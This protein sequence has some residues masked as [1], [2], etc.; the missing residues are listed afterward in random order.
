M[1]LVEIN[2]VVNDDTAAGFASVLA[3]ANALKAAMPDLRIGLD[4]QDTA[5]PALTAALA[6]AG[7]AAA[8]TGTKMND[9]GAAAGFFGA[10]A[11]RAAGW[12]GG[13]AQKVDLFGGVLNGILPSWLAGASYLH[14]LADGILEVVAVLAPAILGMIAFGAA[15]VPTIEAIKTQMS[16]LSTV[17]SATGRS[18]YPL[19]GA[20]TKAADAAKPYVYQLFGDALV[21][22]GN[23]SGVFTAIVGAVGNSLA[24]LGGRFQMAID[25]S[26]GFGGIMANA[27]HDVYML[28]TI[29]GNLGGILGAVFRAV[30]GYAQVFLNLANV[31]TAT[32]EHIAIAG[33]PLL[34]FGLLAHGAFLY[35][36]LGATALA[37]IIP[38]A[39]TALAGWGEKAAY[40]ADKSTILGGALSK[41]APS[42]LGFATGAETAAALPWGWI[43]LAAAGMAALVYWMVSAKDATQQWLSNMQSALQTA[44][45]V[46]GLTMLMAD[47]ASVASQLAQAHVQLAGDMQHVQVTSA[48]VGKGFGII[49]TNVSDTKQ[50]ISE[51]GAGYAQLQSQEA[52]YQTH[53]RALSSQYGGLNIAQGLVAASGISMSL[54]MQKGAGA[55][56]MI[57]AQIL[58]TAKAY[59]AMGQTGGILGA[60]MA[61][62][63]RLTSDQYAAMQKL[64]QAWATFIGR[65]A[66]VETA[67]TGVIAQMRTVDGEARKAR[68]SFTGVN[69]ASLTLRG[70]MAGLVTQTQTMVQ[71]MKDAHAPASALAAE[72]GTV[73]KQAVDAGA[74]TNQVFYSTISAMARQAGYTG[75]SIA[76]LK[77]WIDQN[78]TST[79]KLST[80]TDQYGQ[81]LTKLP[82]SKHTTVTNTAN[83]AN[84]QAQNYI[85][86][87]NNI[88]RNIFTQ[89][90]VNTVH[91]GHA[92]G[93]ITGAAS[94]GARGGMTLVGERGPELVRL[95][96]G[97]SVYSAGDTQSMMMRGGVGGG[98]GGG[99]MALSWEGGN[100]DLWDFLRRGLRA[101]VRKHWGG[102][103]SAA[104]GG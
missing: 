39:L 100:S 51:L 86:T 45:S 89:V 97:S 44:N 28:G 75:S 102:D 70:N 74:L 41:A 84:G 63:N 49:N 27:A 103:V 94:G 95:P 73:L 56:A 1:S 71:N 9:A 17:T 8:A 101:H 54:M 50:R 68:A 42:M 72:I 83:T 3:H 25:N 37:K 57:R 66:G 104:L 82:T 48:A 40:A 61:V 43:A 5:L 34:H 53:L 96:G 65:G 99:V 26:A 88:P 93:G 11:G 2:V 79:S 32:A 46:R 60:D 85:N 31:V 33:E 13:M 78:A 4:V 16:N 47:Q 58:A 80:I 30:P 62:L 19:T 90:T 18:I 6:A 87:L 35:A 69:T 23:K 12:F 98:G 67:L 64:D 21:I 29:I 14:I 52:T 24:T 76:S 81:N 59:Q 20:F 38:G 10:M 36:G 55:M 7:T 22:A 91:T 92:Y 77:S 15:A